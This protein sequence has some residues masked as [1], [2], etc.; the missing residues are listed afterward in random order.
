MPDT[1]YLLPTISDVSELST[2]GIYVGTFQG[3]NVSQYVAAR[4][5]NM[6]DMY[7]GFYTDNAGRVYSQVLSK[8]SGQYFGKTAG[9]NANTFR[10]ADST[11]YGFYY[12]GIG[13]QYNTPSNFYVYPNG[14]SLYEA[15]RDFNPDLQYYPVNYYHNTGCTITGRADAAPGQD[16]V[17]TVNVSLGYTFRGASGVTITDSYGARVPFVV[18]GNQ[19][20]FTMPQP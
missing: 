20:A 8:F 13:Y 6:H 3:G 9:D 14:N 12:K 4:D 5:T 10:Q 2:N 1:F 7:L 15:F 16:V 11:L 17:V 18:N 19:I